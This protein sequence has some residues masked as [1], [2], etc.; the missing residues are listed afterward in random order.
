MRLMRLFLSGLSILAV[1]GAYSSGQVMVRVDSM[2]V[3]AWTLSSS[4][5]LAPVLKFRR[6]IGAINWYRN[7]CIKPDWKYLKYHLGV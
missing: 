7:F 6:S 5:L 1:S 2:R 4:P 3:A